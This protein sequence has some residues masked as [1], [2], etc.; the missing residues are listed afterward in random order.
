MIGCRSNKNQT[1]A[2]EARAKH[3]QTY[4]LLGLVFCSEEQKQLLHIPVK[5]RA[6]I[7]GHVEVQE[8]KIVFLFSGS[9]F[10]HVFSLKTILIL[11]ML[12]IFAFKIDFFRDK[13]CVSMSRVAF[14]KVFTES[15][16]S[17]S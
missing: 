3:L 14:F 12:I 6:Q 7:N 9:K 5:Q 16:T 1:K 17:S 15:K 8:T 10:C 4:V 11:N 2:Q 13:K